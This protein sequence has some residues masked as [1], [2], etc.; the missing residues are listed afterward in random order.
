MST[1]VLVDLVCTLCEDT[2]GKI[3]SQILRVLLEKTRLTIHDIV[4]QTKLPLSAVQ[5]TLA[6]LITNRFA[7][8]WIN[9]TRT[10]YFGNWW[11]VYTLLWVGKLLELGDKELLMKS[12]V[13]GPIKLPNK[14]LYL[15]QVSEHEFWPVSE[16]SDSLVDKYKR[17]VSSDPG[18]MSLSETAKKQQID[19]R[20]ANELY[21]IQ[22]GQDIPQDAP[23]VPDWDKFL[24]STRSE[25][26][27]R[28][29][30]RKIGVLTAK[31]YA[32]MLKLSEKSCYSVKHKRIPGPDTTVTAQQVVNEISDFTEL[33]TAFI[34][35]NDPQ[36]PAAKRVKLNDSHSYKNLRPGDIVNRHIALLQES[37]DAKFVIRVGD[38]G[39][40]EWFLPFE[41][42]C[43]A[44]KRDAFDSIISQSFGSSCARLLRLVRSTGKLDEKMLA[45]QAL[46]PAGDI[47]HYMSIL[48]EYGFV[49]IQEL[50][51]PNERGSGPAAGQKRSM[52]L[53]YHAPEWAYAKLTTSLYEQQ[54][55]LLG[56]R[57]E[58][59]EAHSSLLSKLARADVASAPD[60]FLTESEKEEAKEVAA[61][62]RKIFSDIGLIDRHIKIFREY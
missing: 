12:I 20:A 36:E 26:L 22:S 38:R 8:F 9:G 24:V 35:S 51:K 60:Q 47:R 57:R 10:F 53:W 59:R 55:A 62:E 11:Q 50:S 48:N 2:Y 30:E 44:L 52:F 45:H 1:K 25:E 5:R 23:Y 15:R 40:G 49:D 27:Q 7:L 18:T 39:G 54:S 56:K 41:D 14:E 31:V 42:T 13:D 3:G 19:T 4:V 21:K 34:E 29:A 17:I 43:A 16:L 28:F 6:I 37:I 61:E 33:A 58:L 32:V 46:L